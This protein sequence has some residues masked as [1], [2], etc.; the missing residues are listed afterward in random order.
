M[1]D[2]PILDFNRNY[3]TY[4]CKAQNNYCN[5]VVAATCG[6]IRL[7]SLY[8]CEAF[9]TQGAHIQPRCYRTPQIRRTADPPQIDEPQPRVRIHTRRALRYRY[10]TGRRRMHVWAVENWAY[11]PSSS[12]RSGYV[13]GQMRV[14]RIILRCFRLDFSRFSSSPPSRADFFWD[15]KASNTDPLAVCSETR[16]FAV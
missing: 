16:W 12:Q 6:E 2:S 10:C 7:F 1:A 14:L 11:P 4:I 3:C 15:Q 9:D 8:Q 5:F 13:G